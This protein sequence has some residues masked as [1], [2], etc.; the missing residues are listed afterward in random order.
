MNALAYGVTRTGPLP[1]VW[2]RCPFADRAKAKAVAG[3]AR[4]HPDQKVWY[5]PLVRPGDETALIVAIRAAFPAAVSEQLAA[6]PRPALADLPPCG[7]PLQSRVGRP[8]YPWRRTPYAH[9]REG[10]SASLLRD[11]FLIL[12]EQGTGKTQ[13]AIEAASIALESGIVQRVYIVCPTSVRRTWQEEIQACAWI[14]PDDIALV[15]GNPPANNPARI[16]ALSDAQYRQRMIGRRATWTI[17]HYEAATI[18]QDL[19]APL[20]KGQFLIADEATALKNSRA[21]RTKAVLSWQPA[22]AAMLTGTPVV[23]TPTDV[24]PIATFCEPGLLGRNI[25]EFRD[26][27][28]ITKPIFRGR[29]RFDKEVGYRNLEDAQARLLSIGLRR[30]KKDCLDL[31]PKVRHRHYCEMGAA[32]LEAYARM[33]GLVGEELAALREEHGGRIPLP[34]VV[35]QMVRLQQ[36]TDGYYPDPDHPERLVWIEDA[37]KFAAAD[38]LLEEALACGR[39]TLLWSR[40]VPMARKLAERYAAHGAS[41]LAGEVKDDDREARKAA[42]SGDPDSKVLVLTIGVG[43]LGLNL[44]AGSCEIF[45]DRWWSPA[46]NEQCEDRCHR[47]GQLREVDIHILL[48]ED[49][50]DVHVDGILRKKEGVAAQMTGDDLLPA[51][52]EGRLFE[53]GLLDQILRDAP[54]QKGQVKE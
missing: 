45:L 43:G 31:P 9:Q 53:N 6:L 13:S 8:T 47:S 7:P 52:P 24:F 2:L 23:N 46:V 30:L 41:Y 18:E 38:E 4:W 44:Q 28:V 50:I 39:K 33:L 27:Y 12:F 22:R 14:A 51:A 49:S 34:L 40:F 35:S 5:W 1:C 16:P 54:A 29:R 21:Q 26:R 19:L 10:V 37:A 3:G 32:Q 36:V 15:R 42:F 11:R 17:M 20:V 48:A 25:H